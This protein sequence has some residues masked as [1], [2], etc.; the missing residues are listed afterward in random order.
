MSWR[1]DID[2]SR[3]DAWGVG[4]ALIPSEGGVLSLGR[5]FVELSWRRA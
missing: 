5:W 2:F 4:F 1:I 3:T